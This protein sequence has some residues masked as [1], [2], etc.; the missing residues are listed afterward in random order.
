MKNGLIVLNVVLLIGVAILFYLHFSSPSKKG[1]PNS[2]K[3]SKDSIVY[4]SGSGSRIAYFEMDS[5][6]NS[7][8]MVKDVK[9][10]LNKKDEENQ[11]IANDLD[12]TYEKRYNE[13]GA[14]AKT[15]EQVEA[16]RQELMQMQ[17]DHN[18]RK[19]DLVDQKNALQFTR[20][21]DIQKNIEEYLK[22]FNKDKG[23]NFIFSY[24]RG[25]IY[26]RDTMYNITSDIV[27]GLNDVYKKKKSTS[28]E[29]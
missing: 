15:P 22:D 4:S 2:V 3:G 11:R 1:D 26:F 9:D 5:I 18:K 21:Q 29:K 7:F 28:K 8:E 17:A 16:A 13:L 6:D 24:E 23:Y 20:I 10:E 27:K 19:Q 14:S 25:L 12:R